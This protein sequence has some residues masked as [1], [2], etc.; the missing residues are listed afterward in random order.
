MS[1]VLSL[2][3]T[4]AA[5]SLELIYKRGLVHQWTCLVTTSGI[6]PNHTMESS[7]IQQAAPNTSS[8]ACCNCPCDPTLCYLGLFMSYHGTCPVLFCSTAWSLFLHVSSSRL[9]PSWFL[10]SCMSLLVSNTAPG[11]LPEVMI[12][13]ITTL[14]MSKSTLHSLNYIQRY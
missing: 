10:Y 8:V 11:V 2:P 6:H 7:A 3:L 13:Q 12:I 9:I 14:T 1:G 4:R 5:S